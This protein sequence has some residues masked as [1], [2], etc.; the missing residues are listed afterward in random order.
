MLIT[1]ISLSGKLKTM[2]TTTKPLTLLHGE[3]LTP[4]NSRLKVGA[5]CVWTTDGRL[6]PM[7]LKLTRINKFYSKIN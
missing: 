5:A 2:N 6:V 4:P 7:L 1:D 3:I